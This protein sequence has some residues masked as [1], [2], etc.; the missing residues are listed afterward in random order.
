MADFSVNSF[1]SSFTDK[2]N[3]LAKPTLFT[4]EFTKPP[5]CLVD[6]TQDVNNLIIHTKRAQLPDMSISTYQHTYNGIPSKYPAENSTSDITIEVITSGNMWERTFFTDWQN[7][8][9]DYSTLSN[10]PSF[11]IGYYNE[12]TTNA[13]LTVYDTFHK[14]TKTYLFEG[15]WPTQV[16]IVDM[17]WSSKDQ[18]ML[19]FVT[20]TYSYWSIKK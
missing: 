5:K 14:K 3:G 11:N 13:E 15:V 16:G 7:K 12:Y 17:D 8:V 19:F 10:N 18:M 20:L 9:I 4:F 6:R 2:T 1:R